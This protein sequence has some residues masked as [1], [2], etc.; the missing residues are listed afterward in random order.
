MNSSELFVQSRN[1]MGTVF[2][3]YLYAQDQEQA[4][5]SL[6]A[7]FE[8]VERLELNIRVKNRWRMRSFRTGLLGSFGLLTTSGVLHH[9]CH[10]SQPRWTA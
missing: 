1:A 4:E 5:P 10:L 8:E 7:A 6:D 9:R 2:T 3:I